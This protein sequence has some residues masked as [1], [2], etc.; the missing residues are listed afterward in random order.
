MVDYEISE[1]TGF[2]TIHSGHGTG[3]AV[4]APL[5]DRD[6]AADAVKA[7]TTEKLHGSRN[8]DTIGWKPIPWQT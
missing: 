6:Q 3:N 1:Q 7:F 5:R 8:I 2:V 4:P